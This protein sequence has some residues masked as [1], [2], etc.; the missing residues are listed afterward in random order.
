MQT[1]IFLTYWVYRKTTS[2]LSKD[3]G[4]GRLSYFSEEHTL[5]LG[6]NV[7]PKIPMPTTSDS[8]TSLLEILSSQTWGKV[9][10]VKVSPRI[11]VMK[12][13][14]KPESYLIVHLLKQLQGLLTRINT[15]QLKKTE[16]INT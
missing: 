2:C 4:H 9:I 12:F 1:K 15:W 10:H 16:N 14:K 11:L 3:V 5:I 13:I 8:P 6:G 7:C